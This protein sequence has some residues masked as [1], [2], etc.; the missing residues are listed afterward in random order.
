[1]RDDSELLR[2]YAGAHSEAA[3][4]ELVQRH[5]DLVYFSALRRCGGDSYRTEDIAQ[6]VFTELALRSAALGH[7]ISLVG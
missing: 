3:F 5:I 2:C 7:H 1:M 6:Q 4:A